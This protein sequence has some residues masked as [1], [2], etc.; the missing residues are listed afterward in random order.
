MISRTNIDLKKL[1]KILNNK[2]VLKNKRKIKILR[3]INEV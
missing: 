3:K 1:K 2:G